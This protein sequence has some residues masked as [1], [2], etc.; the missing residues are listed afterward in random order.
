M[1]AIIQMVQWNKVI[2]RMMGVADVSGND[3]IGYAGED[4]CCGFR[5]WQL[6]GSDKNGGCIYIYICTVYINSYVNKCKIVWS[7]NN[8]YYFVLIHISTHIK[9]YIKYRCISSSLSSS[10]MH[11][12]L[13]AHSSSL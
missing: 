9:I 11:S 2:S 13:D 10:S 8:I 7:W 5:W 1:S 4:D 12:H 3:K 6:I